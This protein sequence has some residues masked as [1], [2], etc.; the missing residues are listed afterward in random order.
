MKRKQA[1]MVVGN[2]GAHARMWLRAKAACRSELAVNHNQ[3]ALGKSSP[4]AMKDSRSVFIC[5]LV[6]HGGK[7]LVGNVAGRVRCC[8]SLDVLLAL[9]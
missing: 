1:A 3:T 8:R 6:D 2:G 7:L 9:E 4:N 5:G